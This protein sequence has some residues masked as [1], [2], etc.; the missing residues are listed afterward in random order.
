VPG[1]VH[2]ARDDVEGH[3]ADDE[4]DDADDEDDDVDA[5]VTEGDF[6]EWVNPV[7]NANLDANAEGDSGDGGH[8]ATSGKHNSD[9]VPAAVTAAVAMHCLARQVPL[10]GDVTVWCKEKRINYLQGTL[11]DARSLH[12]PP[13]TSKASCHHGQKGNGCC[14]GAQTQAMLWENCCLLEEKK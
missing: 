5:D 2:I 10:K 3:D 7:Q 12:R 14:C 11:N 9:A 4:D 13:L 1:R 8:R 6:T